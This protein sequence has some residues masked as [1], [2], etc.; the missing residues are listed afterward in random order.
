MECVLPKPG[1]ISKTTTGSPPFAVK[2]NLAH[3]MSFRRASTSTVLLQ[4]ATASRNSSGPCR[5]N[6]NQR[7]GP[8]GACASVSAVAV[9]AIDVCSGLLEASI[10]EIGSIVAAVSAGPEETEPRASHW[11]RNRTRIR[12]IAETL[13]SLRPGLRSQVAI[14]TSGLGRINPKGR[15]TSYTVAISQIPTPTASIL[16]G[17]APR[18]DHQDIELGGYDR[19]Y[20]THSV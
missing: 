4:K 2:R 20:H 8:C 1:S 3:K 19:L 18:P 5:R 15:A 16:L 17:G 10:S 11:G 13:V 7:S 6:A 14:W 12:Y 9:S